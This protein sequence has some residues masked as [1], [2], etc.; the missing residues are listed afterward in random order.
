[1]ALLAEILLPCL[2]ACS[3]LYA[4]YIGLHAIYFKRN[5]ARS[6]A[7]VAG[8][9]Q[10]SV[11]V[12]VPAR[13]EAQTLPHCLAALAQQSYPPAKLQVVVVD[14]HSTDGTAAVAQTFASRLGGRLHIVQ[15]SDP[16]VQGKKA[17]LAAG[18]AAAEGEVILTTDADC[19]AGQQW[20]EAMA[21]HFAPGVAMV[22]GPLRKVPS[23][24]TFFE[25][26]QALEAAGMMALGAA[27]IAMRKPTMANG[28]NLAFRKAAFVQVGGYRGL[29][30]VASG[31]DELL[32]HRFYQQ[33]VGQIVFAG[34]PA[35]VVTTG[36]LPT[37]RA[38][39]K[40]R[41]RWVSKSRAYTNAWI[42]AGQVNAYLGMLGIAATFAA[43]F[44]WPQQWYVL[45]GLLAAKIAAEGTLLYYAT[46]FT[47]QR[48]L[49]KRLLLAQLPHILYVLWV[50]VAGNLVRRYEWK[51]RQV[52]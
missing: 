21:A 1:V 4:A 26:A 20:V 33:Q 34:Q 12:V 39:A 45:A 5:T 29:D 38:F 19:T 11:T 24:P 17:A 49:L 43:A 52:R 41:L 48:N 15:L 25:E 13:N 35:A 28:A 9:Y 37:L 7:V 32:L 16:D 46:T 47:A 18:I 42:T 8:A 31:D 23:H 2:Q 36:T 30:G 3:L 10:P 14:D 22:S 51:G 40:Q 6:A 27:A 44:A 50:G